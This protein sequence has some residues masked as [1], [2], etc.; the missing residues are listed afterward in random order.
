MQCDQILHVTVR[1]LTECKSFLYMQES[2][3]CNVINIMKNKARDHSQMKS[4]Y[5]AEFVL[6]SEEI[7]AAVQNMLAGGRS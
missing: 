7:A 3:K 2:V 1:C 5:R 4:K 6:K